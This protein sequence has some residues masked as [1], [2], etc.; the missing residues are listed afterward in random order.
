MA[1]VQLAHRAVGELLLGVEAPLQRPLAVWLQAFSSRC[2]L[3]LPTDPSLPRQQTVSI[4]VD[5]KFELAR[6]YL[7]DVVLDILQFIQ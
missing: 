2:S 6:P 1:E 3:S 7:D 5:M 4:S